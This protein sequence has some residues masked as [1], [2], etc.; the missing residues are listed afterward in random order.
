MKRSRA[1]AL[2]L[3]ATAGFVTRGAAQPWHY[4]FG[5]ATGTWTTGADSTIFTPATEL[6]G[7]VARVRVGSGGGAF[8]LENQT[9]G[10]GIDAYLRGTAPTGTSATKFAVYNYTAGQAFTIRFKVRLGA[11]DGSANAPTGIWYFFAGDGAS[12]GDNSSWSGAHVFTGIKWLFGASGAITT[13]YRN[14]SAWSTTGLTGTPLSQGRDV[15]VEVYGNNTGVDLT[16]TRNG[17]Q[18]LPTGTFDL[19]VNDTLAGDNLPKALLA[20]GSSID[21]WMFLG[22]SSTSNAANIFVDD[23]MYTNG[24]ADGQLP[25]QLA[26]FT[27]VVVNANCVAVAWKTIS[28]LN[29]YGFKIEKSS[30]GTAFF[31][32]AH[33]FVA[34]N[35]TTNMAA[36]YSFIDSSAQPGTWYYRLAQ[37]DLNG[38]VHYTAAVKVEIMTGVVETT[39][40]SFSLSQNHPNPFNPT[41]TVSGQC[42]VASHVRIVVYDVLGREAEVLMDETRPAGKFAV[43]WNASSFASGVYI[44]RLTAIDASG[45]SSFS[46]VKRM[47]LLR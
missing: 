37:I 7:G 9:I 22:E 2:A 29:N 39:P 15:G 30:N 27:A 45:A 40:V 32:V 4:S 23:V 1:L 46:D 47:T 12:Y 28:E 3:I 35:G 8:F 6:N 14:G 18:S 5:T 43:A 11:S 38:S 20:D 17:S 21:S 16:Y 44:C 36:T 42:P 10:F 19:W 24:I 26:S 25:I 31:E 34:G 41:T 13:Q 33:S